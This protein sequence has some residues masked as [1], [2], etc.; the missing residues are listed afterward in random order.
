MHFLAALTGTT[1]RPAI[2]SLGYTVDVRKIEKEILNL[3]L[4]I[5]V[6]NRSI[7][8]LESRILVLTAI[9]LRG[10]ENKA[11][12]DEADVSNPGTSL[13]SASQSRVS[14]TDFSSQ[15]DSKVFGPGS[16]GLGLR[17][18]LASEPEVS[19]IEPA[20]DLGPGGGPVDLN[21][22]DTLVGSLLGPYKAL[23]RPT[24]GN[25]PN[26]VH[27]DS[28]VQRIGIAGVVPLADGEGSEEP[29]SVEQITLGIEDTFILKDNGLCNT[30]F[31]IIEEATLVP[32]PILVPT[33]IA[34][35]DAAPV[36]APVPVRT[37]HRPRWQ[38]VLARSQVCREKEVCSSW[39]SLTEASRRKKVKLPVSNQFDCLSDSDQGKPRKGGYGI[40]GSYDLGVWHS[41]ETS[42]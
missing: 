4:E 3:K 21:R 12:L 16:C 34:V 6:M 28:E 33:P 24:G 38:Q 5:G 26:F 15:D 18:G 30:G 27:M 17:E 9:P 40:S 7:H 39:N 20:I 29:L 2:P 14:E 8:R 37:A 23:D 36:S 35:L 19:S 25:G 1:A 22:T 31:D 41:E 13:I 32:A 10:S 42:D 11:P